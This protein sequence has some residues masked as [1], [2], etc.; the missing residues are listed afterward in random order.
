MTTLPQDSEIANTKR[1]VESALNATNA[2]AR[3]YQKA[4]SDLNEVSAAIGKMFA[5][6]PVNQPSAAKAVA[7]RKNGK[8]THAKPRKAKIAVKFR[9][10]DHPENTWSGRGR[11]AAWLA[12]KIKAGE[13]KDRYLVR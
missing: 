6:L 8:T 10:P 4:G 12:A 2:L 9:D 1:L 7:P 3:K 11:P 13:S 5:E